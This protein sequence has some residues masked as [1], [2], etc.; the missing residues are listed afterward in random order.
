[1]R[2][3]PLRP[4]APPLDRPATAPAA[5]A[6]PPAASPP[7]DFGRLLSVA[8][9]LTLLVTA[10]PATAGSDARPADSRLPDLRTVDSV[11]Y[12]IRT[13]LDRELSLDLARRMDAMYDEYARRLSAFQPTS[14]AGSGSDAG[15]GGGNAATLN[16][17]APRLDVYLFRT[18]RAYLT[19]AGGQLQNT[20]GVYIPSRNLL[21]AFLDGQGRDGLRRTLQHEAFHQFAFNMISRDFPVWLNEGMA[22]LFEEAIWTGDRFWLGHVPPRRVRQLK[23]DLAKRRLIDFDRLLPMT[24]DTWAANLGADGDLGATQYNQAW[25]MVHYL[26]FVTDERN[27][28]VH[29]PRLI[30]LLRLLHEGRPGDAAFAEAFGPNV[31]GFQD[32]FAE[33]AAVL[34]ATPTATLIERQGVV[35]DLLAE[36]NKRGQRFP[37]VDGFRRAA[38]AGG[39]RMHYTKGEL[40]WE[41]DADLKSYFADMV[42]RP[43]GPDALYFEPRPGA[44]LPDIVCRCDKA[45]QLR[46]RFHRA[47]GDKL[48]HEVGV[49]RPGTSGSVGLGRAE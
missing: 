45:F 4:I 12:R 48:E 21:A 44:P 17:A 29:R 9:L 19:F 35:G 14:V 5:A 3:R 36:L 38:V 41:S 27:V 13:D 23:N 30:Q 22:Q 7:F 15:N 25:A 39:Y 1:M 18:Q 6:A 26:T 33:Y 16:A 32:R 24:Q 10:R 34:T 20:G 47:A 40:S 42:G 43:L 2:L 8:L 31:R 49:E 37:T 28:P 11:H 46:T